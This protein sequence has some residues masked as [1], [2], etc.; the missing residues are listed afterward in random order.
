M[1]QLVS[2]PES[3]WLCNCVTP[4]LPLT[5]LHGKQRKLIKYCQTEVVASTC[6][7]AARAQINNKLN[8]NDYRTNQI[9][10][11]TLDHVS[12]KLFHFHSIL[13]VGSSPEPPPMLVNT[14]TSVW[15]Q[16]TSTA[17]LASVQSAGVVPEVNMRITQA[18]KHARDSPWLWNPGQT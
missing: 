10:W 8:I 11:T 14:S 12:P 5:I 6:I 2:T 15:N 4:E 18:R 9:D 1:E 13:V 7:S 16:K 17:M 3:D